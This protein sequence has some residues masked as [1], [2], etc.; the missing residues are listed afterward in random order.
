MPLRKGFLVYL[1]V[2]LFLLQF[3][4]RLASSSTTT[5]AV[6]CLF[7]LANLARMTPLNR[8]MLETW[9]IRTFT[10]LNACNV[11]TME[12]TEL[13]EQEMTQKPTVFMVCIN[14][15]FECLKSTLWCLKVILFMI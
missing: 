14:Y 7:Y 2:V 9:L 10:P 13:L 1:N 11:R 4:V 8:L 12:Q 6:E 5:R 15:E 3:S